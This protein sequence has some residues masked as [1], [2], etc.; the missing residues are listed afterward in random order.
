MVLHAPTIRETLK[1]RRLPRRP[2]VSR[3]NVIAALERSSTPATN[4]TSSSN[5]GR[6]TRGTSTAN[7]TGSKSTGLAASKKLDPYGDRQD[8][9][10]LDFDLKA[11]ETRPLP[12]VIEG[13]K[14]D[15]E[16]WMVVIIDYLHT[17]RYTFRDEGTRM[18]FVFSRLKSGPRD[19]VMSKYTSEETR[20]PAFE[21]CWLT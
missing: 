9:K 19:M 3:Y 4:T 8:A 1:P 21:K 7:G 13:K 15:F 2:S 17:N 12:E 18:I 10:N 14:A 11:R 16:G 6:G 5:E 20:T